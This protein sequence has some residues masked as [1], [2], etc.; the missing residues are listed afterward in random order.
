MLISEATLGDLVF[1]DVSKTVKGVNDTLKPTEDQHLRN[2]RHKIHCRTMRGF[3]GYEDLKSPKNTPIADKEPNCKNLP[4]CFENNESFYS[5]RVAKY[6]DHHSK[7]NDKSESK[8]VLYYGTITSS[9]PVKSDNG[10][11]LWH[12]Q[13]DDDDSDNED[14][15]IQY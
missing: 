7:G 15:L 10:I 12:V 13:Y 4:S 8:K 11:L 5:Q 6:F 3:V 1:T 14:S 9:K 2:M